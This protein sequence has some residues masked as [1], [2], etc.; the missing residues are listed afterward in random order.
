MDSALVIRKYLS[1]GHFVNDTTK[2]IQE[3]WEKDLSSL[4]PADRFEMACSQ[5]EFARDLV[6]ESVKQA[7]P[8]ISKRDLEKEVF[9]RFYREVYSEAELE[10]IFAHFGWSPSL[11]RII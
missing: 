3:Q 9:L 2:E 5:F 6:R 4:S 11:S 1:K 10:K 8:R 7:D